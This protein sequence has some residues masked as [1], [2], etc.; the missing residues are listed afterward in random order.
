VRC[1]FNRT[2]FIDLNINIRESNFENV[3][4]IKINVSINKHDNSK[5]HAGILIQIFLRQDYNVITII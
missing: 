3:V 4:I 5:H 2:S 1:D